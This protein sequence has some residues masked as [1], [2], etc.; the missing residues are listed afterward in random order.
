MAARMKAVNTFGIAECRSRPGS[1]RFH[2]IW[3]SLDGWGRAVSAIER[4]GR[5]GEIGED[6]GEVGFGAVLFEDG[7]EDPDGLELGDDAA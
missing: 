1:W 3:R 6:A 7:G 5:E 2:P 4:Q